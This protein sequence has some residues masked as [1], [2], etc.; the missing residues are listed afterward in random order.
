[1]WPRADGYDLGIACGR[2][3]HDG[4]SQHRTPLRCR[5]STPGGAFGSSVLADPI[6]IGEY[7]EPD[8]GPGLFEPLLTPIQ[9]FLTGPGTTT[10]IGQIGT[11]NSASQV[12]K[13]AGTLAVIAQTG[14]NNS[15]YQS[16]DGT[17]SAALLVEGGSN[18][19]VLQAIKGNQDFQLVGV[20]GHNNSVAYVQVGNELAG[21]LDVTDSTNSQVLALQTPASGHYLMPTGLHGL[22]NQ[23]VIIVPGRMYV[24]PRS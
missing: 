2:I 5:G 3:E 24:L 19:S 9:P 6:A 10:S 7:P 15:A 18:N 1:M 14:D 20:S 16:V 21:A 11:N 8:V 23:I 13:G 12:T 22:N 17:G 4:I